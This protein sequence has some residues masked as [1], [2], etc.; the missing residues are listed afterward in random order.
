[1][2]AFA[3]PLPPKKE[4]FYLEQVE[5]GDEK[6]RLLLIEHNMRLVAHIVKKYHSTVK[7][8][9]DL[10]SIGTIGLIKAINTYNYKKGNKLATYAAKCIE[11]EILMHLR[12][13]K[14]HSKNVSLYE[15]IGTDK[16]G[17]EINLCDVIENHS[18]DVTE[19]ISTMQDIEYLRSIIDYCLPKREHYII[20]MRYGLADGVEHTQREIAKI[21]GISRSYVSRIEKS[22][23]LRL[24]SQFEKRTQLGNS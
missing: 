24:K 15:P 2:K 19:L 5:A 14:K 4:A 20:T 23:L 21:L 7:D 9:E 22:A 1:M 11:N 3:T 10:L 17:N 8:N 16:E 12:A 18:T 13:E 6:A